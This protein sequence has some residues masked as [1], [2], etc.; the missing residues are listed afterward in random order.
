MEHR[1]SWNT[2]FSP[3]QVRSAAACRADD[4]AALAKKCLHCRAL[5]SLSHTPSFTRIIVTHIHVHTLHTLRTYIHTCMHAYIH[6]CMHACI[7]TYMHA[8]MHTC[9]HAYMHTCIHAYMHTYMHTCIHAYMHTCI[10]AYMHTCIHAY[11]H[12]YI[13]T[14]IHTSFIHTYVHTYIRTYV[15]TYIR[16]YVHTYIRTYVH[17]YIRTRILSFHIPS[18][19]VTHRL[20]HS[21]L[22]HTTVLPC[23]SFTTSFVFPSFPVPATTFEAQY[24]KKLACGVIRS[25]NSLTQC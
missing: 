4:I 20:S 9:I 11:I 13:H 5:T 23:R 22:S 17:T 2:S 1:R 15:H 21:T 12:T 7:H 24:W 8:Y 10:H 25:F 16:T 19:F 3:F 18:C 6:T 14:N